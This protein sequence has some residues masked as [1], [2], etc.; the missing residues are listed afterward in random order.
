MKEVC[1]ALKDEIGAR[2]TLETYEEL[3][4]AWGLLKFDQ[5]DWERGISAAENRDPLIRRCRTS[6][7]ATTVS[8]TYSIGSCCR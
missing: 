2:V 6:W 5:I 7:Q 3:V 8:N 1:A 4:S